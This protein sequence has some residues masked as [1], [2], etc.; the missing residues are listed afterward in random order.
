MRKLSVLCLAL[1]VGVSTIVAF[2]RGGIGLHSDRYG[3]R[4]I[5]TYSPSMAP[6]Q[7]HHSLPWFGR[8]SGYGA[9]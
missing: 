3:R 1:C 4:F 7:N 6:L 9:I 5:F 8:A 2:A